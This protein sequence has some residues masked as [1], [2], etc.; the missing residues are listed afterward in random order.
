MIIFSYISQDLEIITRFTDLYS[1]RV[2]PLLNRAT[3]QRNS[4][5]SNTHCLPRINRK[6]LY[7]SQCHC[8][9]SKT[10]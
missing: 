2:K 10:W 6:S 4:L 1:W 8:S 3:G 7:F 9:V 5:I